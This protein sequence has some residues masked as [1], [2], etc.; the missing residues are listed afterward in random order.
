M[1]ASEVTLPPVE[2][3]ILPKGVEFSQWVRH[4]RGRLDSRCIAND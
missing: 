4:Y 3:Q 1:H 2:T